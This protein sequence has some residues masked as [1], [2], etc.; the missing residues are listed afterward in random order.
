MFATTTTTTAAIATTAS[1][2]K[3][4]KKKD[5]KYSIKDRCIKISSSSITS[6][7]VWLYGDLSDK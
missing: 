4:I 1:K 6:D 2:K 7:D 3:K 5:Y